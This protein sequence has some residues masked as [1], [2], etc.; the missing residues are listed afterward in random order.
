[1]DIKAKSA[2]ET[3]GTLTEERSAKYQKIVF[4]G[5]AFLSSL[6][7]KKKP[8]EFDPDIYQIHLHVN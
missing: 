7:G 3:S 4:L 2:F 5:K 1:L 6:S 8:C